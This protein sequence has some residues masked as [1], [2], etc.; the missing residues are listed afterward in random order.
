MSF[1]NPAY[2]TPFQKKKVKEIA[3]LDKQG[4]NPMEVTVHAGGADHTYNIVDIRNY[5][6][7]ISKGFDYMMGGEPYERS[8]GQV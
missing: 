3:E 2:L 6:E 8:V 1:F 4:L 5:Y 7:S